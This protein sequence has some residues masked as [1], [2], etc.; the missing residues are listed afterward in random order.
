MRMQLHEVLEGDWI[1]FADGV[2]ERI[3]YVWDS[4]VQTYPG[5]SFY[6]NPSG[7]MSQSGAL[8]PGVRPDTLKLT[9]ELRP[10]SAWIFHHGLSMAHNGVNFMVRVRVWESSEA[11][12]ASR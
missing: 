5:G 9:D 1:K 2:Y 10:A 12:A 3:A 4:R 11:A 6:F 8:N 7:R